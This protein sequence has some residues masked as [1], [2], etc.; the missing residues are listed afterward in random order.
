MRLRRSHG[1]IEIPAY[2]AGSPAGEPEAVS[3]SPQHLL[4]AGADAGEVVFAGRTGSLPVAELLSMIDMFRKSGVLLLRFDAGVKELWF[5]EG[6][7]I[8]A[9]ST[10]PEEDLGEALCG[11]G[12][13][14]RD[15][16]SRIRQQAGND[17]A[18][19][20]ARLLESGRV[21]PPDLWSAACTQAETIV[22]HLLD[23]PPGDFVFCRRDLPAGLPRLS[24]NTQSLIMEGLRRSDETGLFMKALKSLDAIPVA[25]AEAPENLGAAEARMLQA[26]A[27][28]R[29]S[30]RELLAT[31]GPA[32]FDGLRT[33]F[34][35]REKGLLRV[36]D[37]PEAEL[38]PGAAR[39]LDIYNNLL[40]AVCHEL[41]AVNRDCLREL[42]CFLR[43]LP[44]PYRHVLRHVE[45]F[46][47]GTVDRSRLAVNLAG[48]DGREQKRMIADAVNEL[49]AALCLAARRDLGESGVELARRIEQIGLRTRA[50]SERT[51]A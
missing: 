37:P 26:A 29:L 42:R 12:R 48:F 34:Q 5:E 41:L 30:V 8:G 24:L 1:R 2:L 43:D 22:Y 50:L 39:I 7:L 19:L 10:L 32:G 44:Q 25:V 11:L 31:I 23:C 17:P 9:G 35:L 15:T 38:D 21:S 13:I 45:L 40:A 28:G 36:D 20:H 3:F 16:L 6:E 47:D 4:L 18:Q 14:D 27:A 49:L 33:L 51:D 46:A